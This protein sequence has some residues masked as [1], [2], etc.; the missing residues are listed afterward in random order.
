[1]KKIVFLAVLLMAI[2]AS[3]QLLRYNFDEEG[4][5]FIQG[6]ARGQFWARYTETNP[7]TTVQ[8]EAVSNVFDFSVRRVR[9]GAYAQVEKK[10]LFYVLLGNNNFN[11][12]TLR[13][14]DL[15]LLDALGQYTFSEKLSIGVAKTTFIGAGRYSNGFSNASMLTLDPS[16]YYHATSNHYDD[17]GR[18]VGVY[19]KG[20]LGKFEYFAALQNS[21]VPLQNAST[22]GF[23]YSKGNPQP[24]TSAYLKYE[25]W[26]NEGSM[27]PSSGGAGTYIGSK[28]IMNLGMG[29]EYQAKVRT[30]TTNT[31][32]A[33]RDY[34]NLG[35]D[36]FMDT[37]I[38]ERNDAITA[39]VGFNA[40]S[41]GSDY[42]RFVGAN[43][44]FEGGTSLNGAGNASPAVGTG[45][46][47]FLQLG[48]LLPK[49]EDCNIRIQPNAGW[50]F[51]N[52]KALNSNVNIYSVGVNTYFNGQ[53]SKLSLGYENRPIFDA[54]D[55]KVDT[56]LGTFVLQYQIEL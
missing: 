28:R 30:V 46:S 42:V 39:Y 13:S 10:W 38:S 4:N 50:R 52:Y 2:P 53:K 26:D 54:T 24:F 15:R 12:S 48:Y 47:L 34:F 17:M 55:K 3:A 18:R 1:M 32:S 25:F 27:L 16:I 14:A 9:L 29:Y 20:Q 44:I 35:I 56:R 22:A 8:G 31:G 33:Y 19:A 45:S 41:L 36:F 11:Q 5:T 23:N 21:T 43:S 49:W 51:A 7:G 37:P 40:I 6:I